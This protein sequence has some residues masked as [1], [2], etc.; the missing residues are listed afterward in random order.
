MK[1]LFPQQSK[2]VRNLVSESDT[3]IP[4][5]SIEEVLNAESK[6]MV[7][8]APGPDG[9]PNIALKKAISTRPEVFARVFNTYL[10]KGVFPNV[11][12]LQKLVLLPK[13][14]NPSSPNSFRPLCML[15]STGKVFEHIIKSRLEL[16][17]DEQLSK[18]NMD[19]EGSTRQ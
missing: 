17:T 11:W 8:K 19:L 9:V 18:T 14:A 12:K 13:T 6:L 3:S 15:D 5:V 16:F 1:E 10:Q 2:F 7:N 4:V